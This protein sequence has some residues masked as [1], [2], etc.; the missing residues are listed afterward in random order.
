[1]TF[2][3][4]RSL[5]NFNLF[6]FLKDL[7]LAFCQIGDFK[8]IETLANTLEKLRIVNCGLESIDRQISKLRRLK[9]LSLAENSIKEIRNLQK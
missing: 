5:N 3:K 8:G 1:M 4:I 7:S 2:T 6:L 9:V